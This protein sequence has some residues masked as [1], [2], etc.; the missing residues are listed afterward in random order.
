[1]QLLGHFLSQPLDRSNGKQ[2]GR[3]AL[4]ER[5]EIARVA[6]I[7]NDVAGNPTSPV[8]GWLIVAGGTGLAVGSRG[9]RGGVHPPLARAGEISAGNPREPLALAH[10]GAD[11]VACLEGGPKYLVAGLEGVHER[12]MVKA[13]CY[14]RVQFSLI[15]MRK[16]PA[17]VAWSL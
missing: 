3:V 11:A 17:V 10:V 6:G 16:R 7:A 13:A 5:R 4:D 2:V 8:L 9:P 12:F 14:Q 15:N 1:M